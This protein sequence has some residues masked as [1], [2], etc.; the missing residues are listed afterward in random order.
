MSSFLQCPNEIPA[1]S[2]RRSRLFFWGNNPTG[3]CLGCAA[4]PSSARNGSSQP[5]I[6]STTSGSSISIREGHVRRREIYGFWVAVPFAPFVATCSFLCFSIPFTVRLG[7][8]DVHDQFDTIPYNY[9]AVN[10]V[11]HPEWRKGGSRL[12]CNHKFL[13]CE[14]HSHYL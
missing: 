12:V 3:K 10:V 14:W 13:W 9:D 1:F 11:I 2:T 6:A 7:E 8:H 5:P 4:G